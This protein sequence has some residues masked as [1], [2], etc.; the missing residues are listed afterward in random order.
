MSALLTVAIVISSADAMPATRPKPTAVVS[1]FVLID[2]KVLP[3]Y[4][5]KN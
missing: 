3:F 5:C 1:I 4:T 2:I